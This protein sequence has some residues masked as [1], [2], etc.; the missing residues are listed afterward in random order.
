MGIKYEISVVEQRLK[1]PTLLPF[2]RKYW[3][4]ELKRL[5]RK[6]RKSK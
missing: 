2:A 3:A 5:K 1:I 4:K 6:R